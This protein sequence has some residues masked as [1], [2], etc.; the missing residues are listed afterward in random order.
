MIPFR[1][2]NV[3]VYRPKREVVRTVRI[4]LFT[5][6]YRVYR[7]IA[8]DEHGPLVEPEADTWKE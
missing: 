2:T 8:A 6:A 1:I 7:Q 5:G 3:F 4:S